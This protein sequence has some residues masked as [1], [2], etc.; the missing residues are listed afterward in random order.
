M[1]SCHVTIERRKRGRS[2]RER[3]TSY[4][5]LSDYVSDS[6]MSGAFR[7]SATRTAEVSD[8]LCSILKSDHALRL[9]IV[10]VRT[11]VVVLRCV[12]SN[13]PSWHK[14]SQMSVVSTVNS[15]TRCLS[16]PGFSVSGGPTP[17][18]GFSFCFEIY[19]AFDSVLVWTIRKKTK[20]RGNNLRLCTN[21]G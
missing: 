17:L 20:L 1:T 9:F 2:G 7:I 12:N 14:V 10:A 15:T 19:I 16:K 3:W 21:G 6:A 4:W 13:T 11:A 8:F 5:A 18:Y